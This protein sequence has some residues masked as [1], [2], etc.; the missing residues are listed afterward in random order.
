MVRL[1]VIHVIVSH[2]PVFSCGER[3]V[4]TVLASMTAEQFLDLPIDEGVERE[5]IRGELRERPMTYR[6]RWHARTEANIVGQLKLWSAQNP[7]CR[8]VAYSGEVGVILR[9]DP[10]TTVGVDVAYFSSDVAD[11]QTAETTLLE[12]TPLLAVEIL[13]PPDKLDGIREKVEEYLGADVRL[14]WIVDPHFQ[15]VVVHQREVKPE[16][17]NTDQEIS[18]DPCLPGFR[19]PLTAFFE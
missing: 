14:V 5:L 8:G 16:L 11:R 15:T 3:T 7:E 10:D 12:G 4:S 9:R 1:F 18:G 19:V 6:N 13:S 17:F 2:S